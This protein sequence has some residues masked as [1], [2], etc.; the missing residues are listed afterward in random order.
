MASRSTAMLRRAAQD[1]S[2]QASA[3]HF[4]TQSRPWSVRR[5]GIA[6][7]ACQ[8]GRRYRLRR[9]AVDSAPFSLLATG[10]VS[11]SW[12]ALHTDE[13]FEIAR[14]VGVSSPRS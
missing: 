13:L 9:R 7:C 14:A 6:H 1:Y 2:C 10:R 5:D 3:E 4:Q 8:E 11:R 12:S